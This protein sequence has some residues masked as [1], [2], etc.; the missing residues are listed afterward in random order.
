MTDTVLDVSG[1]QIVRG[2]SDDCVRI[3][4]PSLSIKAG[5]AIVVTGGSGCGKTS[6]LEVLGLL[7]RPHAVE[8][9]RIGDED[10]IFDLWSSSADAPLAEIRARKLGFVLQTGGLLPYLTARENILLP[11]RLLGMTGNGRLFDRAVESLGLR[12]CLGRRTNKL[13]TGQRQRVAIAR[14]LMHEPPIVLADEPLSALDPVLAE[15]TLDLFIDLV[16][17]EGIALILVSHDWTL[18]ERIEL[19]EYKAHRRQNEVELG[20]VFEEAVRGA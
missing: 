15:S 12:D 20:S 19:R 8:R 5:E 6:V 18:A 7:L 13:S 14:A 3:D 16:R 2:A 11:R 4:V 10:N 17:S 9:F 1:L